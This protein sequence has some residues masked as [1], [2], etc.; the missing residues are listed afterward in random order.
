MFDAVL[1]EII[2]DT[3][4]IGLGSIRHGGEAVT[5]YNPQR[6]MRCNTYSRF[7]S[8]NPAGVG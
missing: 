5:A 6:R 4:S 8:M 2:P 1:S 3:L 7:T